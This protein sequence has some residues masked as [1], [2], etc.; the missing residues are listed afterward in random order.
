MEVAVRTFSAYLTKNGMNA[1]FKT[2][3]A[4]VVIVE[5]TIM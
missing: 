4:V 3:S 5:L 2:Q 1:Y